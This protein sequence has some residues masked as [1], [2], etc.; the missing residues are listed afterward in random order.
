MRRRSSNTTNR[1]CFPSRPSSPADS[2][3]III[4]GFKVKLIRSSYMR[5]FLESFLLCAL[6]SL[7]SGSYL[8]SHLTL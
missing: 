2:C 7:D 4:Q 6:L 3:F 8:F 1:Y 5:W